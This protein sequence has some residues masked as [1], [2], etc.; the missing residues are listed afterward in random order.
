MSRHLFVFPPLVG[1]VNPA[2]G[3]AEEL[4]RRGD[5]VAWVAHEAAVGHLLG[6]A[7]TKVYPA[8]DSFLETAVEL[9]SRHDAL[10]GAASLQFVWEEFL[11]PLTLIMADPVRAA[12]DDFRPDVV[13]ADQ[14]AFAGAVVAEE[15]GLPWAVSAS[16]TAELLDPL[17]AGARKIAAWFRGQLD[18]L[19]D[20]LGMPQ[21]TEAGFDPRYSPHLVIQYSTPELVGPVQR[22]LPS[23]VYVGPALRPADVPVDFPWEWLE[24]HERHVLVSLGTLVQGKGLRFLQR[25]MEAAEGQPYGMV[26]VG[27]PAVLPPPPTNVLVR[28]FVPQLEL[29]ARVDAVVSHGGQ[30]TAAEALLAGVPL[31]CAPIRLDQPITTAQVVAAGAGRRLS[32]GRATAADIRAA[33]DAVL[34]D[35]A[36]RAAAAGIGDALRA[37]GGAARAAD[38]IQALVPR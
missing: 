3:V 38:H 26:L 32:F 15:R 8:G 13:V 30:N 21:L 18:G 27:D 19:F 37:A 24:R 10:K 23:V 17:M 9:M 25:A 7:G 14:H 4:R 22:H 36:Y 12:V 11:V 5:D 1:H 28:P 16:T 35:P 6:G 33:V 29:L 31:V 34:H 2:L 20:R